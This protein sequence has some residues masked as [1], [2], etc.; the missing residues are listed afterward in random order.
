VKPAAERPTEF[1]ISAKTN[2]VEEFA[3]CL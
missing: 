2:L 1:V 3:P